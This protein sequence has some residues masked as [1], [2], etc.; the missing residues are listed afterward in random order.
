MKIKLLIIDPQNDFCWPGIDLTKMDDVAQEIIKKHTHPSILN[1]GALFVPGADQDMTR[2][3]VMIDRIGDKIS[4]IQITL[5]SHHYIDIAHPIFWM[6]SNGKHPGAYD[7][8]IITV[9]DMEKGIW[10]TTNPA[11]QK[12]ALEYV[13]SLESNKRYPLCVWPP[14]CLIGTYG[15]GVYPVLGEAL[16]RWENKFRMVEYVTK[17]SN[18]MTEHY[19][20]VKADV[21]DSNDPSTQ[22]NFDIVDSPLENDIVLLAGEAR[23]HCLANTVLDMANDFNKQVDDF[24]SKFT[25]LEDAT[26][27]V[28][29][30]ENLGENFVKEM[31][32]RG[33]KISKTTEFL[34]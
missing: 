2:L 10:R 14:H 6:D 24:I 16:S 30:F 7:F 3:A 22:V 4:S 32:S 18:Y 34:K 25:L 31:V 1:P 17:G 5:D 15:Y 11:F 28:P 8:T 12:Q 13:K 33:M 26:S 23:S 27:D 20:A 19:S 9:E 29:G 21:P